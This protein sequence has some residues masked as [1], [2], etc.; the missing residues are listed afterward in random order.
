MNYIVKM[1]ITGDYNVEVIADTEE[2]AREI[3]FEKF[4]GADF[5]ELKNPHGPIKSV[6]VERISYPT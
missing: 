3:A 1:E 4:I 6:D 5:G 2:E